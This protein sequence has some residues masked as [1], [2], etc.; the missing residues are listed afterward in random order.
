MTKIATRKLEHLD[1]CVREDVESARTTLLEEVHFLHDALPEL[2]LDEIDPGVRIFDRELRAPIVISGMTGGAARAGEINRALAAAAQKLGFA[3]G[4]GSQRPMLEDPEI[5]STYRVRDVAP[6]ILLFANLGCVQARDTSSARI[7]ALV[8]AVGA[9]ALCLHLNVAQELVQDEGDRN[10]RGCCET[11]VRL[12]R[13]LPVPIVVKETG[14][15]L[16]RQKLSMLRDFGV[17]LVDVAGAGGTSWPGVESL[18]GSERQRALG[19]ALREWGIPTAASVV[20]ADRVGIAAIASGGIR[21]ALDVIRSLAL[22]A[23]AVGLA[24]PFL[25]AFDRDGASGVLAHG[26]RLDETLRALMLLVGAQ[27]VLDLKRL[28]LLL[29]PTLEAWTAEELRG[30]P[31]R[32][33]LRAAPDADRS[34]IIASRS[35][36]AAI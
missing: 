36:E 27:T 28:P 16:S 32:A 22:G 17:P 20:H 1:L 2:S 13:D 6:D 23:T 14:C 5:V 18:R 30:A 10:F 26:E 8:E 31:A 12:V 11:I 34:R 7:A 4:L 21:S 33:R 19:D 9:D 24:L 15:G 25:H 35:K 3:M 29:G